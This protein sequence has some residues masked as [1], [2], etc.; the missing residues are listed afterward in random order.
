MVDILI[1]LFKKVLKNVYNISYVYFYS[2]CFKYIH[3]DYGRKN[4][5]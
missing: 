5:C 2:K 3:G 1:K 4:A